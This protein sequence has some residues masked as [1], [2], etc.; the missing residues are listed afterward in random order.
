MNKMMQ[1]DKST[2]GSKNAKMPGGMMPSMMMGMMGNMMSE[3][4]GSTLNLTMG[5]GNQSLFVEHSTQGFLSYKEGS[6]KQMQNYFLC[7]ISGMSN[8]PEYEIGA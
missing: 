5:Y 6:Q 3:M 8:K 1:M 4:M 7:C 2:M